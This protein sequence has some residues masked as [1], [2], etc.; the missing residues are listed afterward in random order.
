VAMSTVD[1]S[2]DNLFIR[3]HRRKLWGFGFNKHE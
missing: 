2:H 3:K 1:F